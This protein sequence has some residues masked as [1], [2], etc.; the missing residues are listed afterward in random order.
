[1]DRCAARIAS[2]NKKETICAKRCIQTNLRNEQTHTHTHKETGL[3]RKSRS[4]T[5]V[6]RTRVYVNFIYNAW[7]YT[8]SRVDSEPLVM[9]NNYFRVFEHERVVDRNSCR[10]RV[11]GPALRLEYC[12]RCFGDIEHEELPSTDEEGDD[13]YEFIVW[14]TWHSDWHTTVVSKDF[15]FN[16]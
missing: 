14:L 12:W 6:Y 8:H 1:M 15:L 10:C 9:R 3:E 13:E 11:N 2:Y 16:V 7:I 5:N 4:H